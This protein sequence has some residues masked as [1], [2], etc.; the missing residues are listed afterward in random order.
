MYFWLAKVSVFIREIIKEIENNWKDKVALK[1]KFEP[2]YIW[3][4]A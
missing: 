3:Q 1:E 2:R 4:L